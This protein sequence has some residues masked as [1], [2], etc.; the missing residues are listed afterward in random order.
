MPATVTVTGVA[1]PGIT[2]T[3]AVF[4]NVATF[5]INSLN[6]EILEM[7]FSDGRGPTYISI[8]AA[9]TITVTVSGANYTVTIS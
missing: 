5:G 1:G 7:T 4:T 8:A 3:A 9:T 2:V 6:A